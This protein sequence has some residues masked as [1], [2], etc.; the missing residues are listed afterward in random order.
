M[1][2]FKFLQKNSK[3]LPDFHPDMLFRYHY[4]IDRIYT[5]RFENE[6]HDSDNIDIFDAIANMIERG[7]LSS[8][9]SIRSEI[10]QRYY[11]ITGIF[12]SITDDKHNELMYQSTYLT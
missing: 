7:E 11:T 5:D 1:K 6:V 9:N 10:E 3:S 2:T 8:F 12:I 4:L